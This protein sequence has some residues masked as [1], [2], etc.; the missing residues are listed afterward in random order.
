VDIYYI[1]VLAKLAPLESYLIILRGGWAWGY[2]SFLFFFFLLSFF[3]GF[4]DA[5]PSGKKIN[6]KKE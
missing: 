3:T 6:K 4:L 1:L 2:F 5:S